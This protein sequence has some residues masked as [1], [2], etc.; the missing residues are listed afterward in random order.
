LLESHECYYGANDFSLVSRCKP[1]PHAYHLHGLTLQSQFPLPEL[2]Q[3]EVTRLVAPDINVRFGTVP[4]AD[5]AV[6]TSVPYMH[7]M[8]DAALFTFAETGRFLVRDGRDVVVDENTDADPA[9]VRLH[10]FASVMGMLCHQRG[11][12]VLH[13]S[14]VAYRNSAVAFT[15]PPGAGK[16]T[17]AAHCLAAGGQLVADDVLVISFDAQGRAL[18]HPGMPNVKLWRDALD[19]LGQDSEGLRPDWLRANKFHLPADDVKT[20]VPLAQLYLLGVDPA[21]GSGEY[22]PLKGAMAA[23]SLIANTY[24]VEYLDAANRRDAHFRD[25]IRLASAIDVVWLTR[26]SDPARLPATAAAIVHALRQTAD[27]VQA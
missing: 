6:P 1:V 4:R 22:Q 24:R 21:A 20:S 14:A 11:L 12:L 9:L 27:R 7:L 15:G 8:G 23:S 19:C 2:A 10:I 17:L 13:A 5:A 18:A 3:R 25:C 26:E 16:S